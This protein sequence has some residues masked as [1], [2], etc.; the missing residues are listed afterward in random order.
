MTNLTWG[1][2]SQSHRTQTPMLQ[3]GFESTMPEFKQAKTVHALDCAATVIG[4]FCEYSLYLHIREHYEGQTS[5]YQQEDLKLSTLLTFPT[6]NVKH[7]T[8]E[9]GVPEI[10]TNSLRTEYLQ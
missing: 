8:G 10:L 9:D 5:S 7:N 1:T 4:F 6:G 3:V 2:T